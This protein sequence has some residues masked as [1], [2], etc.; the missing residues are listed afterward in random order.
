[1]LGWRHG[2]V[3]EVLEDVAGPPA[4]FAGHRQTGPIVIDAV[5]HLEVVGMVRGALPGGALGG[6]EQRPAQHLRSLASE[7][8][9]GA[10]AVGLVDRDVQP[11]GANRL[12]GAG[13]TPAVPE[14]RHD[15]HGGE[16]PHAVELTLEGSAPRLC[17]GEA[18]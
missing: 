1:R 4:D 13:E 6:L 14:L 17:P 7:V 10:L 18:G 16:P 11:G 2:G 15:G 8:A 5:S 9:S 3:S 12:V